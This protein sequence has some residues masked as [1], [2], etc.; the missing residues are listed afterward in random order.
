MFSETLYSIYLNS[1]LKEISANPY[2]IGIIVYCS[3]INKKDDEEE[4]VDAETLRVVHPDIA[5]VMIL[6]DDHNGVFI[7]PE[8]KMEVIENVGVLRIKVLRTA[9]ARGKVR[10]PYRT[11]DGT[12][13]GGRDF[14]KKNDVL[15]FHNNEIE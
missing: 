9:G 6:D 7:F 11:R 8:T 15:I 10:V 1:F 4:K 12:A 2:K 13:I 14:E 5:T 3:L